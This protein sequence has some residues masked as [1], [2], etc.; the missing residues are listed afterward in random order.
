[1]IGEYLRGFAERAKDAVPDLRSAETWDGAWDPAASVA[2]MSLKSPALLVGMLGFAIEDEDLLALDALGVSAAG[3]TGPGQLVS[4]ERHAEVAAADAGRQGAAPPEPPATPVLGLQP[5]LR[6]AATVV[7]GGGTLSSR[8]EQALDLLPALVRVAVADAWHG[9]GVE[10]LV[11][12]ELRNKGVTAVV[13][14]GWRQL[15]ILPELAARPDASSLDVHAE[16]L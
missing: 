2:R 15:T 16:G 5:Q 9:L 4:R 11:S 10:A 6:L 8:S 12:P 7:V 14:A 13:L 3:A 1:M